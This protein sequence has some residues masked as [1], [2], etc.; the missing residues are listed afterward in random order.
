M[1]KRGRNSQET[2]VQPWDRALVP[3]QGI[4]ITIPL[5]SSSGIKAPT[6]VEDGNFRLSTRL[7]EHHSVT[8]PSTNQKKVTHSAALTPNFAFKNFFLKTTGESGI[9]EHESPFLLAWLCNKP[10]STPNSDILVCLASL[11]QAQE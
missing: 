9:S 1:K 8:S 7:L 6:Q 5:S 10:L 2:T 4:H 3:P 11:R